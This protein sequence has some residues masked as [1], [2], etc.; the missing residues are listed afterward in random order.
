MKYGK[1]KYEVKSKTDIRDQKQNRMAGRT[2]VRIE[3]FQTIE[4]YS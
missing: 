4:N 3:E 2:L 1:N